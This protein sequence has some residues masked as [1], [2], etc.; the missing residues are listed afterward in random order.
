M[1]AGSP[2]SGVAGVLLELT[3]VKDKLR[4]AEGKLLEYSQKVTR[5]GGVC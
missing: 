5:L 4:V 3:E 2:S 1:R